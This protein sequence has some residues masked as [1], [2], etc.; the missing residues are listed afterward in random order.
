MSL[1]ETLLDVAHQDTQLLVKNDALGD[2]FALPRAVDFLLVAKDRTK[3]E[4]VASFVND[5]RYGV[6]RVDQVGDQ[7]RI[8]TV[9]NMP[10]TQDVLCSVSGL[11]ACLGALFNVHYDGWGCVIQK[12]KAGPEGGAT[13]TDAS[14]PP[15]PR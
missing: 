4:L 7:F 8:L 2:D 3:A 11:M 1:V 15:Q 13:A 14:S 12:A 10:T 9:V 5:N 6:A